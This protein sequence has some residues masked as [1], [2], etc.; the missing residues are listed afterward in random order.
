MPGHRKSIF[1]FFIVSLLYF[2]S[3]SADLILSS[4]PRETPEQGDKL[5]GP[6]AANLSKITGKKIVYVH[7]RNW[8]EYA[9]NMRDD[10]YDIVFD[11][12]HFAAWRMKH[13]Q[14]TPVAKL[15][16]TLG[17]VIIAKSSEKQS[18]D[19]KDLIGKTLCGIASPNL[20][21][22][23]A[24]SIFNNPVIQPDIK[25]IKGSVADVY[26]AFA[27]GECHYAVLLD[28]FYNNLPA[29]AKKK[30]KI[31]AKSSQLPNQTFTVS[32]RVT[33]QDRE[34]IEK[35]MITNEAALAA[36]K[37][38]SIYSKKNTFFVHADS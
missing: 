22:M 10:K 7:P 3:V 13:L 31:I 34:K 16:G 27:R 8:I 24:F 1:F 12:P 14:H 17:F 9:N 38:L 6:L 11:G 5:Y 18:N 20:G 28:R 30:M 29:E 23:V 33:P 4:P 37:L 19:L 35:Y 15:V 36:E 26:K 21:T 2:H 25:V 32:K